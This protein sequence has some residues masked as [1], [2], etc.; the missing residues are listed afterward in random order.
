MLT[1]LVITEK[2][3]DIRKLILK[4]FGSLGAVDPYLMK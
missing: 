3:E 2:N 4:L 1:D